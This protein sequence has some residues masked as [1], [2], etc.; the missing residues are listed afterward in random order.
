MIYIYIDIYIHHKLLYVHYI[1]V[2]DPHQQ[3]ISTAQPRASRSGV[4]VVAMTAP[5]RGAKKRLPWKIRIGNPMESTYFLG[6]KLTT[7]INYFNFFEKLVRGMFGTISV[8]PVL[9]VLRVFSLQ[10]LQSTSCF[11]ECP[12]ETT[13]FSARS[14]RKDK[15]EWFPLCVCSIG[16]VLSS[17]RTPML[18]AI[19]KCLPRFPEKKI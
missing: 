12:M 8:H 19:I 2:F 7:W 13:V 11:D 18:L 14:L 3:P 16:D 5:P 9:R 4:P 15:P 1:V 6:M 17:Q 10:S